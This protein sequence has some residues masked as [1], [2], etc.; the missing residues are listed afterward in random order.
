MHTFMEESDDHSASQQLVRLYITGF[1][2][3]L[4]I[5]LLTLYVW[6]L[7]T[8]PTIPQDGI[9]LPIERGMSV[10]AIAEA[11]EEVGIVRSATY[12]YV[13]L[14]YSYD[15][16]KIFAG[17]YRFESPQSVF[18]VAHKLASSDVD[19]TLRSVTIPE[20]VS[21]KDIARITA[22]ML[23][24]FDADT[25]LELTKNNEGYL[26]PETY[27]VPEDYDAEEFVNLLI[28]TYSSVIAPYRQRIDESNFTEYEVLILASIIEREANDETSMRTVSGILQNR[29]NIGMALQ[30]D[31]S[32]EYVL[33]KPL[34]QLTSAD[35]DIDTPYNTYLYPGLVPTPIG[36]PGLQAIIAV[37][38]PI[39]S[40]YF[41]YITGDDGNFYYARTF[42]EHRANIRNHLR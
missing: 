29:L 31:A 5:F 19:D 38:E 33:D 36:N 35:L 3:G 28:E 42:D 14:T 21:R 8:S 30:V 23:P 25:F 12:L 22:S 32:M 2:I 13:I 40:N 24:S 1:S 39:E 15:P 10:K 6:F 41:Y 4:C 34:S 37:L 9:T 11:A 20:G 18:D 26:F 7:S 16:T 17:T 27:F